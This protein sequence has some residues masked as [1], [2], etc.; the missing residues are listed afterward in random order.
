MSGEATG[1]FRIMAGRSRLG[2]EMLVGGVLSYP[3]ASSDKTIIASSTIIVRRHNREMCSSVPPGQS[4][5]ITR[6][7]GR[8]PTRCRQIHQVG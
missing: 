5:W 8:I 3:W 7:E 4:G 6:A 2:D 1:Q